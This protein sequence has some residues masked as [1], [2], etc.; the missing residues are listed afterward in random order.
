MK[1]T[2]NLYLME[3]N[4]PLGQ[5]SAGATSNGIVFVDFE[6]ERIGKSIHN[7]MKGRMVQVISKSNEHLDLLEKQLDEYFNGERQRFNL[8]L[9][10][11]G[12]DFQ[13]EVW[14][15]LEK[16]SYAETKSY[17]T[18]AKDMGKLAAI[19]AIASANGANK[20]LIIIPCHRIIGSS[21]ELTGYA[22][23][24][25]RKEWLLNHERKI[26]GKEVQ[27]LLNFN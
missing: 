24:I 1:E 13:Q 5:V 18:M 19:R 12:T 16:L 20:I 3:Y 17:Q 9:D 15:E 6:P 7:F 22:G 10:L 14:K 2:E 21:G 8:S 26:A 23:G 25:H 27:G 11:Q 4:S